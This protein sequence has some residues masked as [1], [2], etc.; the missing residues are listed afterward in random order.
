MRRLRAI[1]ELSLGVLL[2]GL[3]A[4]P[5]AAAPADYPTEVLAEYVYTCMAANGQDPETLRRCSCSIDR[6]AEKIPFEDYEAARTILEM[7]S[8]RSGKDQVLMFKSTKWADEI[9]DRLRQAQVEADIRCF[10]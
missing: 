6:I 3:M 4:L 2:A 10:R 1:R 9:V 5:L 7:R 8:I